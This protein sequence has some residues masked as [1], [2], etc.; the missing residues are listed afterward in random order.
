MTFDL[1][2]FI[3][4]DLLQSRCCKRLLVFVALQRVSDAVRPRLKCFE[5]SAQF[6]CGVLIGGHVPLLTRTY[7]DL[8][9]IQ[10]SPGEEFRCHQL[11]N[12][13]NVGFCCDKH[14]NI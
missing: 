11:I 14:S 3:Q 6:V 8:L 12:I 7:E 10:G 5:I 2:P 13:P 9:T 1:C 4:F